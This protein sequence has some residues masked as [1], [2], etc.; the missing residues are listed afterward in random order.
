MLK[1]ALLA[2]F[3]TLLSGAFFAAHAYIEI[4]L[5]GGVMSIRVENEM[6]SNNVMVDS[7]VNTNESF[8]A[9][10]T[11]ETFKWIWLECD[12]GAYGAEG[13][14]SFPEYGTNCGIEMTLPFREPSGKDAQLLIGVL[15]T[16]PEPDEAGMGGIMPFVQYDQLV[17]F[18]GDYGVESEPEE[19]NTVYL[20]TLVGSDV[21]TLVLEH[22]GQW[23]PGVTSEVHFRGETARVRDGVAT[24]DIEVNMGQCNFYAQVVEASA[25][26]DDFRTQVKGLT[27]LEEPQAHDDQ[28]YL[29]L[30][31]PGQDYI[32]IG[33]NEDSVCTIKYDGY[34]LRKITEFPGDSWVTL[35][36]VP[37]SV[38]R[39]LDTGTPP[40]N[41]AGPLQTMRFDQDCT[42]AN[43]NHRIYIPAS[44]LRD[45]PN[46]LTS[47]RV[48]LAAGQ[49]EGVGITSGDVYIGLAAESSLPD[50]A[51][52]PVKLELDDASLDAYQVEKTE[53]G[54]LTR[55]AG[56]III[57]YHI[58]NNTAA[59]CVGRQQEPEWATNFVTY[60][61]TGATEAS[62]VD[63][64]GYTSGSNDV[65][66][67]RR[68]EV[69]F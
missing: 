59:D 21:R 64:S 19:D 20:D 23:P 9:P 61:K 34:R 40:F 1:R 31:Y 56:G 65:S 67:F 42:E 6:L 49:S 55:D 36:Q 54:T 32:G 38:Y 51:A 27:E 69:L 60:K 14:R 63:V 17:T 46:T 58:A 53:G 8:S 62:T 48:W 26:G 4:Q 66:G 39:D 52:S 10:S 43:V 30:I 7:Y 57:A 45:I 29:A 5:Y 16:Q 11:A 24:P 22:D 41:A 50:F 35:A 37:T 12:Y 47:I 3:M 2:A 18:R 13:D 15:G 33:A 28:M 25:G 68:L 44:V